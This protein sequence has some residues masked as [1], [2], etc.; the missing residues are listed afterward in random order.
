MRIFRG[1]SPADVGKSF[2]DARDPDGS[3]HYQIFVQVAKN[4]QHYVDYAA[5]KP[6]QESVQVPKLGYTVYW[7][8]GTWC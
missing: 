7:K 8:N 6:G 5:P 1:D 2:G 3:Y 4:G